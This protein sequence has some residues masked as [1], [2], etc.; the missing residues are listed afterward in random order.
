MEIVRKIE[1]FR[2][3]LSWCGGDG[4]VGLVCQSEPKRLSRDTYASD[5]YSPAWNGQPLVWRSWD[6][7]GIAIKSVFSEI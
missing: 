2:Q 5:M 4:H 3:K 1:S 7:L 6:E